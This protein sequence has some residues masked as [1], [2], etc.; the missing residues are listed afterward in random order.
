MLRTLGTT[1]NQMSMWW[2][3]G[4]DLVLLAGPEP[5]RF[6]LKSLEAE[7]ERNADLRDKLADILSIHEP[8]GL[9][10]YFLLDDPALRKMA[11]FGDINTDD[12]T[13]LEYRMPYNLARQTSVANHKEIRRRRQE[14]VPSFL[15]L[16]DRKTAVLAGAETQI[17]SG[18]LNSPLGAPL[19]REVLNDTPES[20]R[21]LLLQANLY[22]KQR[23][24]IAAI[25]YLKLARKHAPRSAEVSFM[26]CKAY[27]EQGQHQSARRA[28]EHC[29]QLSPGHLEALRALGGLEMQAGRLGRALELQK[30]VL[31][32]KPRPIYGEW[33]KLGNL[34]LLTGQ[35]DKALEALKRSLELEPLGYLARSTL[36]QH[37]AD[38]GQTRKAMEELRFLIQYYPAKSWARVLRAR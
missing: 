9:L 4:S 17:R 18:M 11:A 36:A 38:S 8:A 1:F 20:E 22:L 21:I 26:L 31:A 23:R 35:T 16:S 33:A 14:T 10:G 24:Y 27:L 19:V 37:F 3:G 25:H 13:V 12:R 6:S 32:A 7:F 28:L 30:R 29:L 34:Y 15:K 5:R 2:G